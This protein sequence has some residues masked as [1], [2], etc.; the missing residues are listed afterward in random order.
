VLDI[1]EN[2]TERSLSHIGVI[3]AK[4]HKGELMPSPTKVNQYL[5]KKNVIF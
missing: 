1:V 3:G 4:Q 2:S 5:K